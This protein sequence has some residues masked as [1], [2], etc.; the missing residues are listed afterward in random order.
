MAKPTEFRIRRATPD[1]AAAVAAIGEAAYSELRDG[2]PPGGF[3]RHLAGV[4]DAAVRIESETVFLG[5]SAGAGPVATATLCF[6]FDESDFEQVGPAGRSAV[7]RYLAVLPAMQGSGFGRL[8]VEHVAGAA[9]D[10]GRASL[11][12][13]TASFMESAVALY[14]SMGFALIER[15]TVEAGDF[16][17]LAY[18][19]DL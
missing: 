15:K 12:L 19:L 9:R 18:I 6:D 13:L 4:V 7:L 2:Y 1:D 14:E 10:A 16:C 11:G 8:M 5:E 3:E 17:L